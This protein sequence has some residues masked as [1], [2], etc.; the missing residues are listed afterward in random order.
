M[1]LQPDTGA[2][3][4]A[5]FGAV[6]ISE[7]VY[8]VGALDWRLRDFHGYATERGTTYNAYLV[9]GEK[10]TLID[11]VKAPFRGELLARIASV[12]DPSRI[13]YIISN[14]AEMDHTG[15]LPEL[16]AATW[17]ERVFA[18]PNGVN[19]L[20]DHFHP[21]LDVTAVTDGTT[22]DLGGLHYT[23]IETRMLHWPDSMFTW[24]AE[25]RVLFSND[26]FG[27]HLASSARFADELPDWLL[28]HEAAKYYANILLPYSNL[29]LKLAEK[30]R[31]LDL[32]LAIIAPDHGP[33][34][35]DNH[36]RILDLYGRWAAGAPS[37]KAVVIYDTMW[38]STAMMA[39]SI[40]EGL[41]GAGAP[42]T[43]LPLAVTPRSDV[44]TA[45]LNAGALLVGS[46]TLN[47]TLFPTVADVLTYLRGLKPPRL[48]GAAFGSYGWSGEAVAQLIETLRAMKIEV[49]GDGVRVKYVPDADA[50][51]QCY[52]L[53][54]MVAERITQQKES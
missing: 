34:W 53:G 28:E 39:S 15:C 48:V 19:A 32:P 10:I 51:T 54:A 47:N 49:L 41:A 35:R 46:P 2:Q 6:R 7:H 50:L 30:L 40:C 26:A 14:H 4:H 20:R 22:L 21:P 36:G 13:D 16:I 31:A 45:L 29:V 11:A 25:D 37:T 42:V 23:F 3:A 5:P 24:L 52:A 18:S 43:L 38:E 12:V 27:M 44:A 9:M 33:I 1:S 8:W 17:P